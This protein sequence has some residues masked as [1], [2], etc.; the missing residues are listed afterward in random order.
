MES[1]SKPDG[2]WVV[3]DKLS[4]TKERTMSRMTEMESMEYLVEHANRHAPELL[5]AL[6]E[7]EEKPT[8]VLQACAI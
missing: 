5:L 3:D 8:E 7:A 6:A 1:A 2:E 4:F